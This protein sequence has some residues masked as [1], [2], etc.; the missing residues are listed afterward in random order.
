MGDRAGAAAEV[1]RALR[2]AQA[3][4]D[5]EAVVRAVR[6]PMPRLALA[7]LIGALAPDLDS[8]FMPFGWDVYLRVH[9][10]GT[11]TLIGTLP[12]A[13]AAAAAVRG[14]GRLP[15]VLLF[16]VAWL[17]TMS[18]LF[19]DVVSGARIRLLSPLGSIRTMV[20]LVAMAEP[21]TRDDI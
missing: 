1:E 8:V 10:T 11:H 2:V 9:E 17:A 6:A 7:A 15:L 16:Q 5:R 12:V 21:H 18:H 20:P 14:R 4:N 13:L 3:G 19:L